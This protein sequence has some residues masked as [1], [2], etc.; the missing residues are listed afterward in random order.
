MLTILLLAVFST[1]PKLPT[2]LHLQI[3]QLESASL[4]VLKAI[5]LKIAHKDVLQFAPQANMLILLSEFVLLSALSA[6]ITI[7]TL[8]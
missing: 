1:V 6:L 4:S 2:G 5:S 8:I 3:L 7:S